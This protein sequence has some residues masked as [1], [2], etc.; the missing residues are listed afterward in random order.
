MEDHQV[1]INILNEMNLNLQVILRLAIKPSSTE[2]VEERFYRWLRN[3]VPIETI[4]PEPMDTSPVA[5]T[6]HRFINVVT[7]KIAQREALHHGESSLERL[8]V[9]IDKTETKLQQLESNAKEV[10]EAT[11]IERQLRLDLIRDLKSRL[12]QTKQR[13]ALSLRLAKLV[14]YN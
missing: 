12:L 10:E 6:L 4:G 14:S 2:S 9:E 13:T 1:L 8:Q 11:Q 7:D 3:P 5:D